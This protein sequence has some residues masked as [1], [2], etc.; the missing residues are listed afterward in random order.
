MIWLPFASGFW[1]RPSIIDE[2]VPNLWLQP[3]GYA[4]R[5]Q[6]CLAVV[7]PFVLWRA[8]PVTG[9]G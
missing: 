4:R 2:T 8:L 6:W 5:I 1:V 3:T 9:G 7:S